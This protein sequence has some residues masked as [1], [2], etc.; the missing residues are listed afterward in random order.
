MPQ[1]IGSTKTI[2]FL[3]TDN[4]AKWSFYGLVD[5]PIEKTINLQQLLTLI[6]QDYIAILQIAVQHDCLIATTNIGHR[7]AVLVK[8]KDIYKL[9]N[10]LNSNS[11]NII[12]LPIDETRQRVRSIAQTILSSGIL[13]NVLTS[14]NIIKYRF[15]AFNSIAERDAYYKNNSNN[16]KN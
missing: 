12:I 9:F 16:F 6:D 13:F 5:P 15:K 11:T 7:Y 1:Y 2:D 10:Q 3:N 8:D 14:L 4:Y